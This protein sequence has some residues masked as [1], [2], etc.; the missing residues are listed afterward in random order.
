MAGLQAQL[1]VLRDYANRW[2]LTVNVDKTKAVIYR[3]ARCPVSSKP[4]LIYE[5]T[6]IEFV[7]PFN[8]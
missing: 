7:D 1:D 2:G 4:V 5:G 6:S 3:A 8:N